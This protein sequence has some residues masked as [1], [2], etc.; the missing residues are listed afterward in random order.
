MRFRDDRDEDD[1][2]A[3]DD[4]SEADADLRD[5]DDDNDDPTVPCPFCRR[6]ILED[7]PRC[8]YC[9]RYLS[10][11]DFARRSKPLWVLITAAVCLAIAIWLAFAI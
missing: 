7:T 2:D 8:P 4:D 11:D 9:E 6:D 1:D 10:P 5:D 3:W